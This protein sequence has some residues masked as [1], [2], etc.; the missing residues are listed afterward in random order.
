MYLVD[1]TAE[2]V[3]LRKQLEEQKQTAADEL[4]REI[5]AQREKTAR[6]MNIVEKAFE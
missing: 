6:A 2:V 1:P 5:A 4:K 3:E